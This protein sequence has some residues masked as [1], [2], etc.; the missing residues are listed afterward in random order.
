MDRNLSRQDR[1][2]AEEAV[3]S[4]QEWDKL[5]QN[6]KYLDDGETLQ[7]RIWD[8]L[9]VQFRFQEDGEKEIVDILKKWNHKSW[10]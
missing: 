10:R 2:K 5:G 8:A 3:N 7:I 9:R 6:T 1:K 4:F